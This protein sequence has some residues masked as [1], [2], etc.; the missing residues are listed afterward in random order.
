MFYYILLA[1]V[2]KHL[3][4]GMSNI[5]NDKGTVIL[6]EGWGRVKP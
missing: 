3:M 5:D 1:L 4:I 6:M 2:F